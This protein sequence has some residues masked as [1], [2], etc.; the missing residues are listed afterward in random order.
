MTVA[1]REVMFMTNNI[2]HLWYRLYEYYIKEKYHVT[3]ENKDIFDEGIKYII[4]LLSFDHNNS[5][6]FYTRRLI[7]A[8]DDLAIFVAQVGKVLAVLK[9]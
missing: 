6:D 5:E 8:M 3:K 9:H 7:D 1:E 4:Y 2:G